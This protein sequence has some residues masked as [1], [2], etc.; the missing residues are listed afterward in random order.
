MFTVLDLLQEIAARNDT[1]VARV[2]LA[3]VRSKDAVSSIIVGART[4]EQ[5]EEN[6]ASLEVEL[7]TEDIGALD[8][9]TQPGFNYPINILPRGRLTGYGDL[10]HQRR[11]F[12]GV[13]SR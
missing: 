2:A 1:T 6:L 3:W 7:S 8:E 4:I 12:S 10:N 5:L 11:E 13:S 9:L